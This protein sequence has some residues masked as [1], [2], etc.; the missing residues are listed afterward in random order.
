M[1]SIR[2]DRRSDTRDGGDRHAFP[3]TP[4]HKDSAA[5][6]VTPTGTVASGNHSADVHSNTM[7]EDSSQSTTPTTMPVMY[8]SSSSSTTSNGSRSA[9][10]DA[11]AGDEG[12]GA[13]SGE[14]DEDDDGDAQEPDIDNNDGQQVSDEQALAAPPTHSALSPTPTPS[15]SNNI[16]NGNGNDQNTNNLL[17]RKWTPTRDHPSDPDAALVALATEVD[18]L[19]RSVEKMKKD[20]KRLRHHGTHRR[21]QRQHQLDALGTRHMTL[22]EILRRMD[23]ELNDRDVYEYGDIL[24][25]TFG[26]RKI[27]AHRAIGLEALLCQFMH[28]MLA[29]QHQLKIMKRAGKDMQSLYKQSRNQVRDEYHSYQALSVQMEASRLS[30]ENFYEDLFSSQHGLLAKFLQLLQAPEEYDRQQLLRNAMN[31][32]T[33]QAFNASGK[34]ASVRSSSGGGAPKRPSKAWNLR[35]STPNIGSARTRTPV[36]SNSSS[37]KSKRSSAP[38]GVSRLDTSIDADDAVLEL[39][40]TP[41][42]D[43]SSDNEASATSSLSSSRAASTTLASKANEIYAA[44]RMKRRP[45]RSN[46]VGEKGGLAPPPIT[47]ITPQSIVR[48]SSKD[49]SPTNSSTSSSSLSKM[50][51]DRLRQIEQQRMAAGKAPITTAAQRAPAVVVA[52]SAPAASRP[53]STTTTGKK[54]ARDRL[55][56]LEDARKLPQSSSARQQPVI[57]PAVDAAA[58]KTQ[59]MP[60]APNSPSGTASTVQITNVSKPKPIPVQRMVSNESSSSSSSSMGPMTGFEV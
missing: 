57:P 59:T 7:K 2:N 6:V 21:T 3:S 11:A 25:A 43:D 41:S 33:T 13:S 46:N 23:Q 30:L 14:G 22:T 18:G 50:A 56:E 60:Q 40:E 32:S 39:L 51:R 19:D 34:I 55:R 17:L 36:A 31:S 38:S 27:F 53:Q 28:Q 8:S 35:Q 5:E 45:E 37:S 29:K 47:T 49:E 12:L 54:S 24:A 9:V 52:A 26:S 58:T 16:R 44:S 10:S 15:S 1:T 20:L 48:T 42:N 4:S